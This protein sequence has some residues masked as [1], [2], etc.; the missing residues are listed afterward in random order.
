MKHM[1]KIV[2]ALLLCLGMAVQATQIRRPLAKGHLV[3]AEKNITLKPF[4][5][6]GGLIVT[7]ATLGLARYNHYFYSLRAAWNTQTALDD[8]DPHFVRNAF[9]YG[10]GVATG[11]ALF[12]VGLCMGKKREAPQQSKPIINYISS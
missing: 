6:A 3:P 11:I 8:I 10:S 2:A 12:I 9:F 1:M 4:A 7:L 5:I